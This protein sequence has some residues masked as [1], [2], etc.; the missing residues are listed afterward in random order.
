MS[1]SKNIENIFP[2]KTSTRK[3]TGFQ[4]II[5]VIILTSSI[6][7]YTVT[8]LEIIFY[9]L[10]LISLILIISSFFIIINQY[11]RAIILR[12]GVYRGQVKPGIHTRLPLIDNILVIDIREKVREFNAEKML[13]KDNVP[14]T[15]DAILRYR[16]IEERS[17]DALLNVENFNEMIKQVSQTTLRNNIGS[18]NFQEI[19]SK[20]EEINH[21][22]KSI[23][24]K[25]A[26]NWG[27]MVTGVEIR[28]VIIPQELEA[29][30]SMQAQAEREK[31]AR[32]TYG[33]SEILV[34][35]KFLDASKIYSNNPV[36]YALRQSNMLYE[37][38]KIHGNTIIMVPSET[39]NSMGFGNLGTTIAYLNSLESGI[40]NNKKDK[41]KDNNSDSTAIK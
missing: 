22:I 10:L 28:Q 6:I 17:N 32:V 13:T 15:I 19:L 27:V 31:Q 40:S 4:I 9:I 11:E 12:V 41:A 8:F 18:S 36:A 38:M 1:T 3:G 34:A 25:E 37:T 33:D 39:L 16:I 24:S 30:M 21:N 5:G 29:A 23:I 7:L 35:Q 20:R 26:E 2:S 14:V